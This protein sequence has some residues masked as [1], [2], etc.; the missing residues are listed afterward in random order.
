[1]FQPEDAER[2][3]SSTG[4]VQTTAFVGNICAYK[5]LDLADLSTNV[6]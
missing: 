2:S 3:V 6:L 4:Q 5:Q 1:V